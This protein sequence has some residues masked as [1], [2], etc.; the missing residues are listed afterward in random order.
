[1][2]KQEWGLANVLH[3]RKS[4]VLLA[5]RRS[6]QQPQWYNILANPTSPVSC[7]PLPLTPM[8]SLVRALASKKGAQR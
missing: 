8:R 5:L 2:G 7:S 6:Q 4:N 3:F 1:M